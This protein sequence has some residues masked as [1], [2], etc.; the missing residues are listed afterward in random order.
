MVDSRIVVDARMVGDHGHGF[1]RYVSLMAKGLHELKEKS[2]LPYELFFLVSKKEFVDNGFFGF[3]AV[4]V[5]APFLSIR[6][7]FEIPRFLKKLNA[8]AYHTPAFSC[9]FYPT[10][11]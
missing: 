8:T 11:N 10:V 9:L 3:Q 1:A 7:L 4:H 6:Q 2:D 5:H